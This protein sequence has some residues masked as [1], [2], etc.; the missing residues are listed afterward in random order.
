MPS[1]YPIGIPSNRDGGSAGGRTVVVMLFG[2]GRG[3]RGGRWF[4]KLFEF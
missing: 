1:R 2:G 3:V 4:S